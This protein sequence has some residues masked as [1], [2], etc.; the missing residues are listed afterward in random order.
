MSRKRQ[1]NN[2]VIVANNPRPRSRTFTA[3]QCTACTARRA[4][5]GI[6]PAANFT[7]VYATRGDVRYCR[8]Y[9]CGNEWKDSDAVP[10]SGS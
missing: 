2:S 5:L 9:H 1:Q 8:C 3:K 4:A 6:D 7:R 10:Q